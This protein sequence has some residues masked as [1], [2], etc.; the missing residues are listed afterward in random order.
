M[1]EPIFIAGIS[2]TGYTF[3]TLMRGGDRKVRI[4]KTPE[5]RKAEMVSMAALL[6]TRQ[7]F[8]NTTV[9]QITESINVA[10]GLFYYYFPTKDEMVKAVV[11]GYCSGLGSLAEK[12]ADGE[13]TAKEKCSRLFSEKAWKECFSAP[14]IQDLRTPQSAALYSDFCDRMVCHVA[15]ALEKIARQALREK[16]LPDENAATLVRIG[17][18]G[19]LMETKT[20][21]LVPEQVLK[22][23]AA[24]VEH[25][26]AISG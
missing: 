9:S 24:I 15:P 17:L 5:E 22:S 12:V 14:M 16:Q 13:R 25:G 19:F 3:L 18:Y 8:I 26:N 6:F 23:I 21:D 7:G 2:G 10:K 4:V 11:E 20:A 1:I